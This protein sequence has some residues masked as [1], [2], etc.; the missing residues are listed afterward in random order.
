MY[1]G[2]GYKLRNLQV[3]LKRR[4]QA[5]SAGIAVGKSVPAAILHLC[6]FIDYQSPKKWILSAFVNLGS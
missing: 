6:A 4:L 3:D 2:F 5:L 1:S